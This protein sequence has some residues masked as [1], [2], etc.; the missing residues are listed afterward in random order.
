MPGTRETHNIRETLSWGSM[1]LSSAGIETPG[2][3]ASILLAY[4]L[5]TTREALIAHST[6]SVSQYDINEFGAL[7]NRRKNGE[8]AAYITGKKEFLGLEFEVNPS[9]LVPRPETEILAETALDYLKKRN[10]TLRVLD[11]CTGSGAIAVSLKSIMPRLE[12]YASDIS[13]DALETARKNASRLLGATNSITFLQGDLFNALRRHSPAP[14]SL[15]A[16]SLI[17]CNPPY[18]P[19]VKISSLPREVQ[20]E[21][22]I[23]LEGGETGFFII[24]RII[25]EAQGYLD[26]GSLLLL[27]ADPGQMPEIN[28]LFTKNNFH[29]INIYNDLA[30]LQ[31][32]IGGIR[33]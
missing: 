22:R 29:G 27:E 15:P 7:L 3:D 2:L 10:G 17:A 32:V 31:R 11:L 23:A 26:S 25:G 1:L 14:C 5:K 20:N 28:T 9:V 19:S 33:D 30:G 24:S 13:H 18:I 12:V 16:F 21:P 4:I 8:C 6:D